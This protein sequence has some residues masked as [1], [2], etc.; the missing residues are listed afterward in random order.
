MEI[1]HKAYTQRNALTRRLR[2]DIFWC[3]LDS[4]YRVPL[5]VISL[6]EEVS[7]S[8]IY[9]AQTLVSLVLYEVSRSAA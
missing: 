5:V 8:Y 1:K 4:L 2:T 6:H 7:E 9:P 3:G